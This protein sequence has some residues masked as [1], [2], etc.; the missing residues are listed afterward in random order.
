MIEPPHTR[1]ESVLGTAGRISPDPG[2]DR[3]VYDGNTLQLLATQVRALTLR[4][5]REAP[6][7]MF[8][9]T[10]PGT[11]NHLTWHLGHVLW[12][13][14]VLCIQPATGG[15]ELPAG[16]AEQFG[17]NCRPPAQSSTWP[18]RERLI[19]LLEGQ[20]E[21]LQEVLGGLSRHQLDSAPEGRVGETLEVLIVHGWHDEAIHQGEMKLLGKLSR[22]GRQR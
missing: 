13:Q 14:D 16:W 6:A 19:E 17:M 5:A 10:P 1:G 11:Q 15:S 8:L 20:R 4:F 12:V 22:A 9:W 3:A 7:E 18:N 21:Q 2:Y